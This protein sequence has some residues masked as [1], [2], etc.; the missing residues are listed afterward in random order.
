MAID[1]N[2]GAGRPSPFSRPPQP[3]TTPAFGGNVA[4]PA[5]STR[6]GNSAFSR[7]QAAE[8]RASGSTLTDDERRALEAQRRSGGQWFYWLAALSLIN[9][10]LALAGQEWRFILGLGVT[11]IVQELAKSG[12]GATMAGLVSL[13]VIALFAGLGYQAVKGAAWAFLAGMVLYALDGVV[14][15]LAQHW[16]GVGFHVFALA[17]ILRGYLASRQLP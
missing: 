8:T 2:Q 9:S 14:F 16:V 1:T 13:A 6:P 10:G 17:M 12:D 5:P 4:A 11:Q 15:L 7:P 3:R